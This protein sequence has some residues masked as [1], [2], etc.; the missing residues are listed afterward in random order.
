MCPGWLEATGEPYCFCT[1]AGGPRRQECKQG[2]Q[3][4]AI[5]TRQETVDIPET[6]L[7]HTLCPCT[8]KHMC[9]VLITMHRL[10]MNESLMQRKIISSGILKPL[11]RIFYM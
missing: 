3:A 11:K 1:P 6:F 8:H 10:E 9:P 4:H 7:V 2:T 5:Q